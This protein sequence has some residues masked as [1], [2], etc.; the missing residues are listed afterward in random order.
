M[1]KNVLVALSDLKSSN[2]FNSTYW[3]SQ[4]GFT[5]GALTP[6]PKTVKFKIPFHCNND[7]T[8]KTNCWILFNSAMATFTYKVILSLSSSYIKKHVISQIAWIFNPLSLIG[9]IIF[10]SKIFVQKIWLL[11][12]YWSS[13]LQSRYVKEQSSF[14]NILPLIEHEPYVIPQDLL[15]KI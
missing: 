7:V 5:C 15:N 14:N 13:K 12:L 8:E 10:S 6:P 1:Y 3:P 2:S 9:C 11:K 4:N